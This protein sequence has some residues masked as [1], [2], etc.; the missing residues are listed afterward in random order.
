M[1][2]KFL[3]V[4][5]FFCPAI[6][7]AGD[8]FKATTHEKQ[9]ANGLK[10]IVKQDHRAPIVFSEIWYKVGSSYE[11]LGI[12]GISHA[13]EHM[14]FKGT[15][16]YPAGKF[17]HII[18]ENGGDEN[19]FTAYDQTAYFQK[20]GNDKLHL[21]FE[22]ESD[23]MQNLVLTEEDFAKEI[24]VVK[25]ERKLR[26]DNVPEAT[27]YERFQAAAYLSNPYQHPIVGWQ[28][29]LDNMTVEDL[30]QWYQ[31]WYA[32]NNAILVV[33]GDVKPDEVFAMA[34]KYFANIRPTPLPVIKPHPEVNALG[35]RIVEVRIPAKIPLAYMGF[36][37]P[38]VPTAEVAWEPYALSVLASIL[39]GD[40]SS[41]LTK[42]LVREQQIA[43]KIDV[44][45]DLYS[46]LDGLFTFEIVPSRGH[47]VDE[48]KDAIFAQIDLLQQHPIS[49]KELNRIKAQEVASDVFSQDS[50]YYQA[51]LI[52]SMESVGL[53]WREL[54]NYADHIRAVTPEQVQ[55]VAKKY[56]NPEA[57]VIAKLVPQALPSSPAVE[58]GENDA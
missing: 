14:M 51:R 57:I 46:R 48:V 29:D 15:K 58:K 36:N 19:A 35:P 9:L 30:R 37:T 10:V 44:G 3:I 49:E 33:V 13:L 21:S 8:A 50:L 55:A 56:L 40:D 32:P 24:E 6:A 5:C 28:S 11:P 23:R 45:Y 4:L 53:S 54:D 43:A 20:L 39:A 1:M 16:K 26:T 52:G 42:E 38:S 31:T 2:K 41:R 7:L 27:T 47:S 34:E 22:L 17:S 12:T 18:T 25:E